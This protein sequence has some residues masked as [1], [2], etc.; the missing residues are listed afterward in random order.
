[1]K[2]LAADEDC[3]FLQHQKLS[4]AVEEIGRKSASERRRALTDNPMSAMMFSE[5]RFSHANDAADNDI[6]SLL[7]TCVT[8]SS[9]VSASGSTGSSTSTGSA[10]HRRGFLRTTASVRRTLLVFCLSVLLVSAS[11]NAEPMKRLKDTSSK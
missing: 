1:M 11:T 8:C 6:Y 7:K 9:F 3:D 10:R 5:D 4:T 2:V